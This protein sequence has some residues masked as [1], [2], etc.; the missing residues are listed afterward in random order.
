ML[1]ARPVRATRP[2]AACPRRCG[3][4]WRRSRPASAPCRARARRSSGSG[5][6]PRFASASVAEHDQGA[7]RLLPLG[8][9]PADHGRVRD[10][11]MSDQDRLHLRRHHVLAA[12]DDHLA[13][14][15]GD[16]EKRLLVDVAE[17]AGV[18]PAV[19]VDRL[20]RA[21]SVP[22][23][24]SRRPRSER[25]LVSSGRPAEPTLRVRVLRRQR[26]H[27]GAGLGHPVGLDHRGPPVERLP[28]GRPEG[29]ARHRSESRAGR[30]V[31]VRLEQPD[32]LGRDEREQR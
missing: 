26:R 13:A 1:A 10:G 19:R 28:Q 5:A 6:R 22:G 25:A 8:I 20:A 30:E 14:A 15:T 2:G 32:Q 29:P 16:V 3:A 12:G 9:G 7:D 18:Q 24:G 31:G 4:G 23:P 27:L 21:P 11:G 17:V